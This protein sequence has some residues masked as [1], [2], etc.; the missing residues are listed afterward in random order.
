MSR[1]RKKTPKYRLHKAS[2][3]AAVTLDGRDF[4]LGKHGSATSRA[5]YDRLVGEWLVNGRRLPAGEAAPIS[6]NDLML[7]YWEH[8]TTY[9]Q[10][11]GEP[12]SEQSAIRRAFRVVRRLYGTTT[13]KDFGPLAL[14][15]CREQFSMPAS[16]ARRSTRIAAGSGGCS[17]GASR[18]SSSRRASST[19]SRP[20]LA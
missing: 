20:S 8:C 17:S 12:T 6:L 13:A 16:P 1:P 14:K 5:E 4:Y 2:G 3:Q 11:N 15:T 7:R 19:P 10:R 9:Y 18:T